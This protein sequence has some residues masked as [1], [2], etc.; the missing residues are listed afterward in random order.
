MSTTITPT[1]RRRYVLGLL[2]L[3]ASTGCLDA[4]SY[5]SLD[6]VFTGN[7]T[8]NVLFVGFA[9]IGVPGIPLVNNLVALACFFIG[10]VVGAR[11]VGRGHGERLPLRLIWSLCG[12]L[13]STL[14]IGV[15]WVG[16]GLPGAGAKVW[17]TGVLAAVLGAQV[18]IIKPIGNSDLST[19]VVTNTLANLG[20]DSAL[21]GGAGG[22]W[23]QRLLAVVA[24]CAGAV[25]GAALSRISGGLSVL[26]AVAI[27]VAALLTF[28]AERRAES[29]GR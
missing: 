23:L 13:G 22:P 2:L 24:M 29:S 3:T 10:A 7:M 8:G 19:V 25:V 5:L 6:R 28:I 18:A 17:I 4:V 12:T 26:A 27:G 9:L 21:G 20:R 1:D 16:I 15:I 11:L 14:V